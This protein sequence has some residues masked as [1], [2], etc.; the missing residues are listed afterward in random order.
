MPIAGEAGK[1]EAQ[2][3]TIR[4]R[5]MELRLSGKSYRKIAEALV[6]EGLTSSCTDMTAHAHVMHEVKRRAKELGEKAH[7]IRELEV[8]RLDAILDAIW[9]RVEGGSLDHI[10]TFLK[11]ASRRAKLLGLDAATRHEVKTT[12]ERKSLS[13]AELHQRTRALLERIEKASGYRDKRLDEKPIEGVIV[14]DV[15][16]PAR[17]PSIP[18]KTGQE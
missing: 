9:L 8:A 2:L 13:D 10:E 12:D 3:E 4:I 7:D 18:D 6:A 16:S 15:P 11:V 5:A 14:R 17:L 1:S